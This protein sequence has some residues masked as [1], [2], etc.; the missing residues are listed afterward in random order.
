MSDELHSLVSEYSINSIINI[1][2]DEDADKLRCIINPTHI[3]HFAEWKKDR[4]YED[5]V[6][7]SQQDDKS[8]NGSRRYQFLES[9]CSPIKSLLSRSPSIILHPGCGCGQ[10]AGFLRNNTDAHYIGFDKSEYIIQHAL[11]TVED[12]RYRFLVGDIR[13]YPCFEPVDIV[14]LDYEFLNSFDQ[15]EATLIVQWAYKTLKR[16]GIIFGDVRP[17]LQASSHQRFFRF[18]SAN[19]IIWVR[20][21]VIANRYYGRQAVVIDANKPKI[22]HQCQDLIAVHSKRD[23]YKILLN[24]KWRRIE[25][26]TIEHI[27]TDKKECSNNIRFILTK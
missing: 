6:L 9:Y 23:W 8:D 25:I 12:L 7:R 16:G 19:I 22:I 5:E 10:W 21:G 17:L 1:L 11:S 26:D 4:W 20:R 18:P 24:E 2:S 13:T 27:E 3:E 15:G 14:L